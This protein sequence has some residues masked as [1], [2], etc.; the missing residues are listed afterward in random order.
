MVISSRKSR[1]TLRIRPTSRKKKYG[2]FLFKLFR[3]LRRF[4]MLKFCTETLNQ[5]MFF[6]TEME[7][8]N[9]AI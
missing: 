2:G 7:L 4:T 1:G 5:P 9:W 8:R 6:S 3:D